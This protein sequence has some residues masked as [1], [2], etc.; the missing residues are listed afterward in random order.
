MP[1]S[2]YY[3]SAILALF[4]SFRSIMSYA[5]AKANDSI[6]RE[7]KISVITPKVFVHVIN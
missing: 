2:G 5:S 4:L 3:V 1:P 6:K 7:T